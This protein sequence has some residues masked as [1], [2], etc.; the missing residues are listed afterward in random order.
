MKSIGRNDTSSTAGAC[1]PTPAMAT[2]NPRV[3]ASE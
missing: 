3:A 1:S 2:M